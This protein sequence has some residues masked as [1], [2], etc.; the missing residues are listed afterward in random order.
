MAHAKGFCAGA[1]RSV[2]VLYPALRRR[3]NSWRLEDV[4]LRFERAG[5]S[6][7]RRSSYGVVRDVDGRMARNAAMADAVRM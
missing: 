3:H 7:E 1:R 5:K 4:V 2:L 6:Q